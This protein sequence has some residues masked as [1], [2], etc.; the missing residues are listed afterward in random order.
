MTQFDINL[1]PTQPEHFCFSHHHIRSKQRTV[2]SKLNTNDLFEGFS[3]NFNYTKLGNSNWLTIGKIPLNSMTEGL[4]NTLEY[5]LKKIICICFPT[6][7]CLGTNTKRFFS[8]VLQIIYKNNHII[9][10][11]KLVPLPKKS[12]S[13]RFESL[14]K[15]L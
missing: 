13:L 14:P 10:H 3:K 11:T 1:I 8:V 15:N 12:K 6:L 7:G 2:C 5:T 4:V 9:L